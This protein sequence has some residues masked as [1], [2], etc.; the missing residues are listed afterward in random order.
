MTP[1]SSANRGI[2]FWGIYP[3]P[4][5]FL[6]EIPVEMMVVEMAQFNEQDLNPV[7]LRTSGVPLGTL[8]YHLYEVL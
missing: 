6:L 8:I 7:L 1:F 4:E 2:I 5:P 3:R